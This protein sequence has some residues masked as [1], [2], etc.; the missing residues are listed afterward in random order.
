MLLSV[1]D[2][3]QDQGILIDIVQN[4]DCLEAREKAVRKIKNERVLCNI[5]Q[6][7]FEKVAL[8]AVESVHDE[9]LLYD[10]AMNAPGFYVKKAAIEKIT[11]QE[12]LHKLALDFFGGFVVS[13]IDNEDILFD[14]FANASTYNQTRIEALSK[15]S[16][17]ERLYSIASNTSEELIVK[18]AVEKISDKNLLLD[19]AKN[20]KLWYTREIAIEKLYCCNKR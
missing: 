2:A 15:L 11:N 3:I 12:C 7:D 17:I 18:I 8:A 16:N 1:V 4:S 6:K 9:K 19:I 14:I 13:G 20:A 5:A 10:I